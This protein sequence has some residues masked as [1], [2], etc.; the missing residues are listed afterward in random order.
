MDYKLYS[1]L[2]ILSFAGISSAQDKEEIGTHEIKIVK[3]Y[4][5][6]I[7]EATK[8]APAITYKPQFQDKSSQKKVIYNLPDRVEQ[9]KFEPAAISP[10]PY[11]AKSI[12]FNTDNYVKIGLGTL[13]NPLVEWSHQSHKSQKSSNILLTHHSAW[14]EI[15]EIRPY[16]QTK[17]DVSLSQRKKDWTFLPS[18]NVSHQFH[19]FYG[20]TTESSEVFDANRSYGKIGAG[21]SMNKEKFDEKS[22][23]IFNSI[24]GY[25]GADNLKTRTQNPNNSELQVQISS[26]F[27]YKFSQNANIGLQAGGDLYQYSNNLKTEKLNFNLNPFIQYKN[28]TLLLH[29]G[30][31]FVNATINSASQLYFLPKLQTAVQLVPNYVNLYSTWERTLDANTFGRN[32]ANNPFAVYSPTALVPNTRVENRMVGFKGSFSNLNYNGYIHQRILKDALLFANDSI[33]PKYLT[34]ILERNL[35]STNVSIELTYNKIA[36]WGFGLKG[37]LFAYELDNTLVAYNLPAQRLTASIQYKPKPKWMLRADA[38]A[39]GGVK[40][41]ISGQEVISSTALDLNLGSEFQVSKKFYIFANINNV[42][43]ANMVQQIGYPSYGANAQ[44][45]FRMTY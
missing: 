27:L 43:N 42:F 36:N 9:F 2:A 3:D 25:Y 30:L 8:L 1:V 18:F 38:F 10:V 40:S 26:K 13:L 41:R 4:N 15:G 37:D 12:F 35:N 17:L 28:K 22:L 16:S 19:H 5:V 45:G 23:S 32:V 6:F 29:A 34:S 20:N 39:L 7:E 33:N 14:R 24:Q 21:L 44:L 11:R 31:N